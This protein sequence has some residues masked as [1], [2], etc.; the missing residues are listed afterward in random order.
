MTFFR[1]PRAL[2]EVVPTEA[3]SLPSAVSLHIAPAF[4]VLPPWALSSTWNINEVRKK[5]FLQNAISVFPPTPG[6]LRHFP[7]VELVRL[8]KREAKGTQD[9]LASPQ[10]PIQVK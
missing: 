4:S 9:L 8:A 5:H 3:G 6:I 2:Y 10:R 7:A 1:R